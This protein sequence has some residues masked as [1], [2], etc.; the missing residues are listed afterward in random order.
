LRRAITGDGGGHHPHL[1]GHYEGGGEYRNTV[2]QEVAYR[3][4]EAAAA[5]VR[6]ATSR[7]RQ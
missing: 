1:H 5:G 6:R 2:A 7:P 3:V 4:G